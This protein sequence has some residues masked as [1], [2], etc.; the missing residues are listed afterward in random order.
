M[1]D[2]RHRNAVEAAELL[3]D[4]ILTEDEFTAVQEPVQKMWAELPGDGSET[5]R[6]L[7]SATFHLGSAGA[8][9]FAADFAARALACSIAT[10]GTPEW[11]ACQQR[12]EA[13]L[14][15]LSHS[16]GA[17]DIL[18][19]EPKQDIFAEHAEWLAALVRQFF[20]AERDRDAIAIEAARIHLDDYVRK[21]LRRHLSWSDPAWDSASQ[22]WFDG[23]GAQPETPAPGRLRMCDDVFWYGKERGHFDPFE[24]EIELCEKTGAFQRYVFRFGDSRPLS[25]KYDDRTS[26]GVPVGGWAYE[27]QKHSPDL[28]GEL[29]AVRNY[30]FG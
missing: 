26:P 30:F 5:G 17:A 29:R 14:L 2:R 1:S 11:E 12:E 28:G 19:R 22:R 24:F 8:A 7:T 18:P 20:R 3:L 4:G 25:T 13:E 9:P 10:E 15:E 6:Y 16:F 21:V 23:F 27:F